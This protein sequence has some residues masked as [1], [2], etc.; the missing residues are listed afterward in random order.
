MAAGR[1][2]TRVSTKGQV[3]LPAEIRRRRHWDPGTYLTVEETPEG[4]RSGLRPSLYQRDRR[5]SLACSGAKGRGLLAR[6]RYGKWRP[7]S[8]PRHDGGMIA[9]DTNV[10]VRYLVNDHPAQLAW[11]RRL[12]DESDVWVPLTVLLETEWVLRSA[13]RHA[14][15]EATAALRAFVGLPRVALEHAAR[16]AAALGLTERG[17]DF[18][19]APH[20]AASEQ[21]EAFPRSTLRL[22]GRRASGAAG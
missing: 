16:V 13:Y 1:S 17:M 9:V 11:A 2:V 19:D 12:L 6:G 18:A 15:V 14:S 7:G 21:C 4:C 8:Q 5:R 22:S 10:V 3:V 20:L